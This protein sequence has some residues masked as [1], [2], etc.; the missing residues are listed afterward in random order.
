MEEAHWERVHTVNDYYDGPLFGVAEYR[1]EPH[2]Y[3]HE[4]DTEADEYGPWYCLAPIDADLLALILEG[5]EIWLRWQS[6][7]LKKQVTRTTHPALPEERSRHEAIMSEIGG[8]FEALK[9]GPIRVMAD[10]RTAGGHL[11]VCWYR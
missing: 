7:Y 10:F 1:G 4:F 6:A 3:D 11:E 2:V 5:W 9:N 8:R